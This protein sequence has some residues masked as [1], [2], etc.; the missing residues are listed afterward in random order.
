MPNSYNVYYG[1]GSTKVFQV[2]FPYL[3]RSHLSVTVDDV[4]ATGYTFSSA[5]SITFTTAPAMNAVIKITRTTPQTPL[6]DFSGGQNITERDLDD[7]NRQAL[8]IAQETAEQA[9]SQVGDVAALKDEAAA[10]LEAFRSIYLGAYAENP[11]QTPYGDPITNGML[12]TNTTVNELKFY[13]GGQWNNVSL[14][15]TAS[16]AATQ[17]LFRTKAEAEAFA[18]FDT[19][20]SSILLT[21]FGTANEFGEDAKVY[22]KVTPNPGH[23]GVVTITTLSEGDVYYE[24]STDSVVTPEMYGGGADGMH[25]ALQYG[26]GVHLG[27]GAVIDCALTYTVTNTHLFVTGTD[28]RFTA[29]TRSVAMKGVVLNFLNA[30]RLTWAAQVKVEAAF[31]YSG[32][33]VARANGP[34]ARIVMENIEVEEVNYNSAGSDAADLL[35]DRVTPANSGEIWNAIGVGAEGY[36]TASKPLEYE[37]LCVRN[38]SVKTVIRAQSKTAIPATNPVEYTRHTCVGFYLG[39]AK[40]TVF[41]RCKVNG[42]FLGTSTSVAPADFYD[43]DA[44]IYYTEQVTSDVDPS[45]VAYRPGNFTMTNCVIENFQGRGLKTKMAGYG[46][47]ENNIFRISTT[48]SGGYFYLIADN[49]YVIDQQ[50]DGAVIRNNQFLFETPIVNQ[51]GAHVASFRGGLSGTA[52][53]TAVTM[54]STGEFSENIIRLQHNGEATTARS[55][56]SIFTTS[57]VEMIA[58][59]NGRYLT[60]KAKG[61]IVQNSSGYTASTST[62]TVAQAFWYPI[63]DTFNG[64]NSQLRVYLE[65]NDVDTY[66]LVE[67]ASWG[68]SGDHSGYFY[69]KAKNNVCHGAGSAVTIPNGAGITTTDFINDGNVNGPAAPAWSSIT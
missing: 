66:K 18:L 69:V 58:S 61:N 9:S 17:S 32:G 60:V 19:G 67:M 21:G 53:L 41:D 6:V 7:V 45:K 44:V 63:L 4:A 56:T 25:D 65:D 20:P 68:G 33:I 13:S 42:V 37:L 23:R 43:A 55:L 54:R 31:K 47:I 10:A 28:I 57:I 26:R 30:E 27:D 51:N 3:A 24:P 64:I 11:T 46:L 35:Q 2:T 48:T 5:T 59:G 1:D 50:E 39:Q 38:C 62:N 12:Y 8:Y 16:A 22:K 52:P 14:N 49:F 15:P 36:Y 34:T 29:S 40:E